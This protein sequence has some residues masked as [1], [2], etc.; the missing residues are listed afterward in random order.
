VAVRAAPSAA[1]NAV[2]LERPGRPTMIVYVFGRY[3]RIAHWLRNGLLVWLVGSGIYL[4]N[5]FLVASPMAETSST[6]LLAQVRGW[7][8]VAGWLLL[9]L[10]VAR[11]YQFLFVT[12]S[13]KLGLGAEVRMVSILFNWR[14]WRDQLGFY[15]LLRRDH[16]HFIY[17]NY[18]PLQY[19]IYIVLYLSLAVISVTGII[20]A[21]PYLSSG[22]AA[23][24]ASVMRPI[25][26]ALG[27]LANVRAVHRFTMWWFVVFT[28]IHIYM[29][30]WNS[31]RSGNMLIEGMISGFKAED[32]GVK[33]AIEEQTAPPADA[34]P[35]TAPAD[36]RT[37]PAPP[38]GD[39][40]VAT[41]EGPLP[42]DEGPLG[43]AT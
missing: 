36:H 6:F 27:G 30:V 18:G 1:V 3:V 29:A 17:S 21:S 41:P 34:A 4:G 33:R 37:T 8:V 40:A 25:E 12:S 28:V 26:V 13:G 10:T 11:L 35:P 39:D 14:A 38:A 31:L 24:G 7:H 2:K 20:L 43:P 9:A 5:P 19:L 15:L 42:G 16:P 32:I 23:F 22:L